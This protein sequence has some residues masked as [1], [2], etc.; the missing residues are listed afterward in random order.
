MAHDHLFTQI[1][2]LEYV[3]VNNDTKIVKFF[4]L[5]PVYVFSFENVDKQEEH[6]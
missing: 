3:F 4:V 6:G 2:S 1:F 5:A